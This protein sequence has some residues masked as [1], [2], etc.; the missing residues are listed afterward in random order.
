M[1][2][3]S[4]NPVTIVSQCVFWAWFFCIRFTTELQFTFNECAAM[5]VISFI[6]AFAMAI[7]SRSRSPYSECR[8]LVMAATSLAVAGT[9]ARLPL[10][11]DI[12]PSIQ[13]TSAWFSCLCIGISL[14]ALFVITMEKLADMGS[15]ASGKNLSVAALFAIAIATLFSLLEPRA[16]SVATA[17]LPAILCMALL[18]FKPKAAHEP[19]AAAAEPSSPT[20]QAAPASSAAND[21]RLARYL[22][23]I[24]PAIIMAAAEFALCFGTFPF[25]EQKIASPAMGIGVASVALI[26]LVGRLV[27]FLS[28]R[29][30]IRMLFQISLPLMAAGLLAAPVVPEGV[31]KVIACSLVN[32]GYFGFLF[33][34]IIILNEN[35][36]K[37]DVPSAW[38]FGFLRCAM[39]PSQLIGA[40]LVYMST[41]MGTESSFI[42]MLHSVSLLAVVTC[43]VTFFNS[44]NF[45]NSWSLAPSS[46]KTKRDSARLSLAM[47]CA[48]LARANGLTHREEEVCLLIAQGKTAPQAADE[49]FVSKET[50]KSHLKHAYS[51]LG[52]HSKEELQQKVRQITFED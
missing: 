14:S 44:V 33:L 9:L 22:P 10:S 47:Q 17:L 41:S 15:T 19:P 21:R 49:L 12:D 38:A 48:I 5:I 11:I 40:G 25:V 3:A 28:D 1:R 32:L 18:W 42:W 7:E 36:R 8:P 23:P 34:A 43:S 24:R 35:C 30:N 45:L 20:A 39:L 13:V 31:Q 29:F 51:K 50:V 16:F 6:V 2:G 26:F 52:I 46:E 4:L 37:N 27:P